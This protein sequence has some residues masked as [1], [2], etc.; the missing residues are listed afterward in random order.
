MALTVIAMAAGIGWLAF[1]SANHWLPGFALWLWLTYT[2]LHLGLSFVLAVIMA[3]PG[4]EMRAIPG[5]FG[6]LTGH[7][8]DEH[9]CPATF[10]TAIDN[11]ERGR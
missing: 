6:R 9:G 1:G 3:T 8:A 4:C 11:W 10:I 5:L 2:F 7:S